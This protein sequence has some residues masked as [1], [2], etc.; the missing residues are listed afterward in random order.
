MKKIN[1]KLKIFSLTILFSG[2]ILSGCQDYLD[3]EPQDVVSEAI[4]FKTADQF[5]NASNYFYTRLHFDYEGD[6]N[7]RGDRSSDLSGN[8]SGTAD[9][10]YGQGL[11]IIPTSEDIWK[12]NYIYLRAIN[13]LIEKAADYEDDQADIAVPVATAYY[14]RAWHYYSLLTR[15]GGVPVIT[16]SLDVNSPEIYA[17]RN[18]RYEV[19]NQMLQDLDMAIASLPSADGLDQGLVS[20]EAAK[21]FKARVLLYEATWE[22]YVGTTTDGDGTSNGAGSAKPAGYPDVNTMFNEAKL[23]AS[24]IMNSGAFE[25]WD[26]RDAIGDDHLYYLFNLEDGSNPAGLTKADN[27]EFIFQTVF[28]FTIRQIRKNLSHAYPVCPTRKMMDMYLCTDGLPVQHSSVFQGYELMTSEF[29]N[30]D[31]RLKAFIQEPLV[32]YWGHGAATNGGGAQYGVDFEDSGIE[33]DYRYVPTLSGPGGGRNIGYRGRKFVTEH[34]LR[35]TSSESFNYPQIRLAEVMLIYAEAACELN[36]GSISDEDLNMSINKIRERSGVAPLT[37]A[38]IAPYGDLNMIGEIRRERA[39]EL[40]GEGF[41]FDDLKRWGIAEEELN[42]DVCL[43]YAVGTEY[44]TA[45]NPKDPGNLILT[46]DAFPY[47]VTSTEKP[48]SGYAG[49]ATTKAGAI[50]FDA[51]GNRSWTRKNYVDPIP[52]DEIFLNSQLLQNPGW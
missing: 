42:K 6:Q 50:I 22:K 48:A 9:S 24:Q 40:D 4:Y 33:F 11:S 18:S 21:S 3:Q 46:I 35:E 49:I 37:N 8:L 38:L 28:D 7:M 32:Q 2:L 30:R 34:I 16:S 29:Q 41:R 5:E 39:I 44:E 20:A 17:P 10:Y 1:I 25:L 45:E 15:Y 27:K 23:L 43:V 14:F 31:L 19:V 12:N 36:G 47:G 13:Q 26:Q 51:A 52:S